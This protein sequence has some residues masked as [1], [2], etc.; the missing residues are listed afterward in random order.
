[1]LC[2]NWSVLGKNKYI[3]LF[4]LPLMRVSNSIHNGKGNAVPQQRVGNQKA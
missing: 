3:V 1:M 4:V 2:N